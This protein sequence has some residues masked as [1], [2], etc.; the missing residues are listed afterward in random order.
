MKKRIKKKIAKRKL[1]K[2]FCFKT[3]KQWRKFRKSKIA[4]ENTNTM[5]S[6]YIRSGVFFNNKPIN[7]DCFKVNHHDDMVDAFRYSLRH[8]NIQIKNNLII[9]DT[10]A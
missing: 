2:L 3:K 9:A 6:K 1:M 4:R 7:T 5:I 10:T 8:F